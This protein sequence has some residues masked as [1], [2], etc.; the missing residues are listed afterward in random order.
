MSLEPVRCGF[1][2][3]VDCAPLAVARD[4]GFAAEEGIALILEKQP[5][6]SALR[7][8]LVFGLTDCAHML[9]PVPVAMSLG[10]GG[11]P[12]RIDALMVLS[13]NGNVIGV[14][15]EIAAAMRADGWSGRFDDP[16]GTGEHLIRATGG[17]L[18][19]AVPFPFS[20]H[21]E[22]VYHWLGALG[23]SAPGGLDMRTVPP[24]L[25][26][27]ALARGE[28]DAFCVGEPW[29]SYAVEQGSGELILPGAAIWAFAPEKVLAARHDWVETN[30]DTAG[31]LMRALARASRW[32]SDRG[33][34]A[35]AGDLLSRPEYLDVP[36]MIIDRALAGRII[37]ARRG[38]EAEAPNFLHFH[39]KAA[40][41]PWRS[42]A[43]WIASNIARRT[44]LDRGE[45]IA[46]GKRAFRSDLY[47]RNLAPLGIDMPGASE[48]LEGSLRRAEAVASSRGHMILGPDSFF[49]ETVFD[50]DTP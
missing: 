25:M 40:T 29:G 38:L 21:A 20:M 26:P 12:T 22:L 15:P 50:P 17:A 42:Q 45:A 1:I 14:R 33:N 43:A 4:L 24:P 35:M 5:S 37:T 9:S 32:L 48:K 23:V 41:F 18:R 3:L 49:D 2:P 46:T 27:R 11:L 8:A 34:R 7:D 19:L 28:I 31:R 16:R 13:V 39:A 36:P 47:R 44:G 6:W 30:P 10:L